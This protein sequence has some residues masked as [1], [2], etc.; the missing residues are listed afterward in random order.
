MQVP[1]PHKLGTAKG[2]I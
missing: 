1:L 2:Q